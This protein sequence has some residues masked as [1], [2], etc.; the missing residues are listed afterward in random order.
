MVLLAATVSV[1]WSTFTASVGATPG[2]T[3]VMTVL[4][5]LMPV[6]VTLGPPV[7][8]RPLLFITVPPVV[9][10]VKLGVALVAI[11]TS[12]PFCV[13]AMLLPAL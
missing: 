6:S 3:L 4:P 13:M 1:S 12:A 10:L 5:A 8:V 9:T 7:I 11:C 2:A